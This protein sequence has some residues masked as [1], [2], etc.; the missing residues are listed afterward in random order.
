MCSRVGQ[1][2]RPMASIPSPKTVDC[3]WVH[4]LGL[5]SSGRPQGE[6]RGVAGEPQSDNNCLLWPHK[7]LRWLCTS[8]TTKHERCLLKRRRRGLP[9]YLAQH[10]LCDSDGWT[11]RAP[12]DGSTCHI[13]PH[14][15]TQMPHARLPRARWQDAR[16]WTACKRSRSGERLPSSCLQ[17]WGAAGPRPKL[18]T[19][20]RAERNPVWPRARGSKTAAE[21]LDGTV[22]RVDV[23]VQLQR[24]VQRQEDLGRG[25]GERDVAV[26]E[27]PKDAEVVGLR[28]HGGLRTSGANPYME[29]CTSKGHNHQTR[30]A[31]AKH[32]FEWPISTLATN[33]RHIC[34]MGRCLSKS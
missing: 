14:R 11:S 21:G 26:P 1:S 29:G 2:H 13:E 7:G 12:T 8:L 25:A 19:H 28:A 9:Q 33:T 23:V 30:R 17:L 34:I 22:P 24:L 6:D 15:A 16:S 5:S 3:P 31:C 20:A 10:Q 27:E 32:T 4:D 18:S